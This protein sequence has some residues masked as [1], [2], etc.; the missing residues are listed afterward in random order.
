[1]KTNVIHII[2]SAAV[3]ATAPA[4]YARQLTP[5]EALEAATGTQGASAMRTPARQMRLAAT[6][7]REGINTIYAFNRDG[8]GFMLVAADDVSV[9]ILAYSDTGTFPAGELAPNLAAWLDVYSAQIAAAA[10]SGRQVKAA[11]ALIGRT[12]VTP[13]LKTTWNQDAPFNNQAP[14]LYGRRS[15]TGCV[16]TAAAQLLNYY[17]WPDCG[18]GTTWYRWNNGGKTLSYN[19]AAHPFDWDNMLDSYPDGGVGA[20][21]AQLD[22]VAILMYACGMASQMDYSPDASGASDFQLAQGLINNLKYDKSL[23]WASRDYYPLDVWTG[24][25]YDEISTSHPVMYCGATANNEGHAFVLDGYSSSDGYFHVNWGW[26]GISDGY[27]AITTLSPDVQGIGGADAGFAYSQSALLGLRKATSD[28]AYVPQFCIDGGFFANEAE[29]N[30]RSSY[31]INFSD[32][33]GVYSFSLTDV[34]AT[35]ALKLTSTTSSQVQYVGWANGDGITFAPLNGIADFGA[36]AFLVD[37]FPKTGTWRVEPVIQVDNKTYPIHVRAGAQQHLT[38]TCTSSSLKFAQEKMNYVLECKSIDLAPSYTAGVEAIVPAA[39]RNTGNTESGLLKVLLGFFYN[40]SQ[41]AVLATVDNIGAG[42]DATIVFTGTIP[43]DVPNGSYPL[44]MQYQNIDGQTLNIDL[45]GA[46]I[47]VGGYDGISEAQ[48]ASAAA[49]A[50]P[51]PTADHVTFSA[52][53]PIQCAT[54]WRTDGTL[55]STT[56][57]DSTPSLTVSL[58][59]ILPGIYIATL[60][61]ERGVETLRIIKK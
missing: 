11:T 13:M 15:V 19:F 46:T 1:M 38:V 31:Y 12:D 30:R 9:P 29:I 44:L 43:A 6:Y 26:G 36:I 53:A 40:N 45:D 58:D 24:M 34:K 3:L 17:R 60:S 39:L 51:N 52:P 57:G 22:A 21:A 56:Q 59:G 7:S 33:T 49:T 41:Q 18:E 8:D 35:F 10:A 28:S 48:T 5:E 37:G 54:L 14:M 25:I 32:K 42:S 4:A 61:T 16:A 23:I 27:F 55:V 2:I 50:Y 20:T 47:R